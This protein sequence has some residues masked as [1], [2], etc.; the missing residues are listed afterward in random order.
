VASLTIHG[1][2]LGIAQIGISEAVLLP[3]QGRQTPVAGVGLEIEVSG[4]PE[5][6]PTLPASRYREYLSLVA[7]QATPTPT[8]SPSATPSQWHDATTQ[9]RFLPEESA[10]HVGE[11]LR[12]AI[13]VENVENLYGAEIRFRY[14]PLVL[15]AIDA[16]PDWVGTQMEPGTFPFPDFVVKNQVDTES[17]EIWYAVVQIAPRKGT[18]GT[19]IMASTTLLAKAPGTGGFVVKNLTLVDRN[20]E[21]IP[22]QVSLPSVEVFE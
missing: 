16:E 8:P 20:A 9:V 13:W 10:L 17:G 12:L 1:R 14:D 18:S 22:I 19:G 7:N 3:P 6:P 4:E 15:E 21:E 11:Q 5:P 2:A